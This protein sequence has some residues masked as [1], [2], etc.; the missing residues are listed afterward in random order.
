M[1]PDE[2]V[3][4]MAK[5]TRYGD[6]QEVANIALALKDWQSRGGFGPSLLLTSTHNAALVPSETPRYDD[7]WA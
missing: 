1:D 2:A 6:W 4:Q 5:A 3:R 7:P